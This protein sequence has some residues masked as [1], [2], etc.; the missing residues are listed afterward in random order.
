MYDL[1]VAGEIVDG[2]VDCVAGFSG[3]W[4]DAVAFKTADAMPSIQTVSGDA[5]GT[6]FP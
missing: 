2:A 1:L 4:V 3:E 5:V 6:D